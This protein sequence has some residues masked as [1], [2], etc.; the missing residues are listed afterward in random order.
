[1]D[2]ANYRSRPKCDSLIQI[3]RRLGSGYCAM[4]RLSLSAAESGYRSV[5]RRLIF[6]RVFPSFALNSH[7]LNENKLLESTNLQT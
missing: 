5:C 7:S 2:L 1:M 3:G 6:G 4:W